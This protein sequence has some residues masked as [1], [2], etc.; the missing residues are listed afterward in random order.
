MPWYL[1]I[2]SKRSLLTLE[3][4]RTTWLGRGF[5]RA[6]VYVLETL[7]V[8]PKGS[9][10]VSQFLEKGADA[11]VE[12][13]RCASQQREVGLLSLSP[14]S[15]SFSAPESPA[16]GPQSSP[17]PALRWPCSLCCAAAERC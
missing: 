4:F 10:S 16:R 15:H 5:T 2:D 7:R 13:G 8:A 17:I 6:L 3:S 9:V 1:P 11:L 12:G 14:K